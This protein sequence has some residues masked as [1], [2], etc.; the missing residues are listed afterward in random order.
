MRLTLW[1]KLAG[2][3]AI[4]VIMSN[5]GGHRKVNVRFVFGNVV[6]GLSAGGGG[7]AIVGGVDARI[8]KSRVEDNSSQRRSGRR[9]RPRSICGGAASVKS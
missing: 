5:R 3:T 9:A 6:S 4:V 1:A 2:T 7:L 8:E